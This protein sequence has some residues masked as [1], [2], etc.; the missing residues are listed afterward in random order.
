[1]PASWGESLGPT[2]LPAALLGL[3]FR[4]PQVPSCPLPLRSLRRPTLA[5]TEARSHLLM[6]PKI[7]GDTPPTPLSLSL[8]SSLSSWVSELRTLLV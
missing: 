3:A 7:V 6:A 2:L 8:P 1:M 4:W 5:P